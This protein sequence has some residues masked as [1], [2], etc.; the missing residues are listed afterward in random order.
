MKKIWFI[1]VMLLSWQAPAQKFFHQVNA[2]DGRITYPSDRMPS[3]YMLLKVDKQALTDWLVNAPDQFSGHLSDVMLRV[4]LPDNRVVSFRMYRTHPMSAENERRYPGILSY[5]GVEVKGKMSMRLDINPLGV[6][7][8]VY[9]TGEGRAVM[10]RYDNADTYIYYF[11]RNRPS[12]EDFHCDVTGEL[13]PENLP[14]EQARPA[15]S[16]Q[17]LRTF[18]LAFAT[19]GEFSSFHIQRAINNG[20]L[21]S[22][23]TDEEKKQA[24]LAAVVV[25]INRVNEV[26]ETDLAIHLNLIS[27]TN[28]IYLDANNDPYT[29]DNASSLLYENQSNLDNVIGSANYD[30]GHVGT[31]G[32]GGLAGLGV[33]CR[34][35][36][37]ARGETGLADPVGDH[38]SIDFVAHEMGHQF[39]GNHTFANYCGGNRNDAT[40]V[41]PGSGTTIMAYAGVCA[42]NVQDHSDPYFHYVSINEIKNYVMGHDCSTHTNLSNHAP[43][44]SFGPQKYIPKETPFI[45]EVDASDQDGDILTFTFDEKDVYQDSGHTDA[46][47]QST[48]TTGPLFR[49]LPATERSYRYFPQMADIINGNYGNTWEVLP[50]VN[51]V[52]T[53]RAVVR[54]NNDEGGQIATPEQVLGVDANAGP[55]RMTSQTSNETWQPGSTHTITWNVAGTD[56]GNVNTPTVDIWLSTDG[57][58]SF[59]IL[60]A[61]NV[62]NDGSET[63]TLPSGLQ[64]PT[65]RIMV[66]GHNNYFFDVSQG[67]IMIGNYTVECLGYDNTTAVDIPD[68]N[69]TGITSTIHLDENY[70][71]SKLTVDVNITH[72]YIQDL[73]I[74]LT[75]PSGT[76]VDLFRRNCQ[77]QDNINVTFSDDGNAMDCNGMNSGGTYQPVGHLSD[78]TGESMAGDWTLSVSDNYQGD[79]GTLNSWSLHPCHLVGVDAIPVVDLNIYPNPAREQVNISFDARSTEQNISLTDINGRLV[80]HENFALNGHSNI[81][82]PVNRLTPGIYLIKIRDGERQSTRKLVIR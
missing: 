49:C 8:A 32:G 60:L 55:F 16:D 61:S 33:V 52:L 3:D 36:V 46:A 80:W 54:D 67:N 42:P 30:I 29:N 48:N 34:D 68:N 44:A 79:V 59:D 75:S 21:S 74:T 70:E 41:E 57:G 37:K 62:P 14:E 7:M 4:P 71:I 82:I 18:R 76:T 65:G 40:A 15:F 69:A 38:Y 2:P 11:T 22:N 45:L 28:I 25:I 12:N 78:F 73:V 31:T 39:G 58:D 47:P 13:T 53:F 72:T 51:R 20:T 81:Q 5:R 26:Y 77:S 64:T 10:Q 19:T 9:R 6:F 27:G 23:A 63:V 1:L 66:R 56:A 24:V 35:G 17:I 50:S 43:T